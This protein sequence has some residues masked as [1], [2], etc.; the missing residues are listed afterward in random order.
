MT[1][2]EPLT[3]GCQCGKVRYEVRAPV[4]DLY[5]CHCSMCRKVHGAAFASLAIAPKEAVVF[6]KGADNLTRFDSSHGV[7][8]F[9]CKTCGCQLTID[10]ADEPDIRWFTAATLDGG[11]HPGAADKER[12][13]FVGSKLPWLHLDNVLP[14][15]EEA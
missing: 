3:G 13:I 7:S 8:R 4:S 10:V 5:H 12:H 14:R 1:T 15:S 11:V 6:T 9:F 2:S